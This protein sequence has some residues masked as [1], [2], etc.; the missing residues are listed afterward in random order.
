M[1][2]GGRP[3]PEIILLRD[4]DWF[5]GRSGCGQSRPLMAKNAYPF[6]IGD[7][8]PRICLYALGMAAVNPLELDDHP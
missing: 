6:R 5:P 7:P 2:H 3:V 8:V 4:L 1:E